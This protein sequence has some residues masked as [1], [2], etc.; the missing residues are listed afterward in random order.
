[1]TK[2]AYLPTTIVSDKRSVFKSQVIRE[3]A[4]VLAIILQQI[5][6]QHV[7][8]IGNLERTQAS[9]RKA[10]KMKQVKEDPC[11]VSMSTLQF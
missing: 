4:E 6:T 2:H 1:M 5:T 3:V 11:G 7:Q 10:L 9:I 8:T